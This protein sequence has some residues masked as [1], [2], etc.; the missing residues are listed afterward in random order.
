MK[1]VIPIIVIVIAVAVGAYLIFGAKDDSTQNTTTTPASSN[2]ESTD[3][4]SSQQTASQKTITYDGNKFSPSSITVMSGDKVTVAN[5]SSV[6]VQ[7]NSDP[8]PIH[9]DDTDLNVG[10]INAGDSAVFTA[11]RAGTFGYHNHLDQTQRGMITI[12]P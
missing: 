1:K 5:T 12:Q 9:T 2:S 4:S 6:S 7:F 8:H 3:Q 11:T 10:A